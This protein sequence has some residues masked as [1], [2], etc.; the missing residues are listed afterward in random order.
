[1]EIWDAHVHLGMPDIDELRPD[2]RDIE[3]GSCDR[4]IKDMDR[5]NIT[6]SLIFPTAAVGRQYEERNDEIST[7]VKSHPGKFIGFARVNPRLGTI[8][9]EEVKRAATKLGLRGLKLHPETE[10]FRP[11]HEVHK[12]MFETI[13]QLGLIVLIHSAPLGGTG[14]ARAP[15]YSSPFYIER[16]AQ[17]FPKLKIILSHLNEDSLIVMERNQNMY[18]DTAQAPHTTTIRHAL[19]MGFEDRICFGSD[20]PYASGQKFEIFRVKEAVLEENIRKKIFYKNLKSLLA[21]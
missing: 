10:Q 16:I 9:I 2:Q 3:L 4:L 20:W 18:A 19:E 21:S 12:P 17:R 15:V 6:R 5:N 11:D 14:G 7:C 13:T 1:M 8:A